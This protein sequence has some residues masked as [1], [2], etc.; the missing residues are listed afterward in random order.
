MAE[1]ARPFRYD[2]QARSLGEALAEIKVAQPAPPSVED[3]FGALQRILDGE[4]ALNKIAADAAH[5]EASGPHLL[6]QQVLRRKLQG[7]LAAKKE[8][9]AASRRAVDA[10]VAGAEKLANPMQ[11]DVT[12]GMMTSGN[13][14]PSNPEGETRPAVNQHG[15]AATLIARALKQSREKCSEK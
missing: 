2:D 3:N 9:T 6:E 11:P 15:P 7:L 14:G 8:K 5:T 1:Q 10:F 4:T 12:P 13:G